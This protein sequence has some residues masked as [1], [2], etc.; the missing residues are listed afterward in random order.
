MAFTAPKFSSLPS[1]ERF[2][3]ERDRIVA[4]SSSLP[5]DV[6]IIPSTASRPLDEACN[7]ENSSSEESGEKVKTKLICMWNN[8]KYRLVTS[9]KVKCK[10]VIYFF[11]FITAGTS[12]PRPI[13]L[14]IHPFGYLEESTI[15]RWSQRLP[16]P[17]YPLMILKHWKTTSP[18]EYGLHIAK[19]FQY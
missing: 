9:I 3:N 5:T 7:R 17:V 14:K 8:V 19:S 18:Q 1:V 4:E 15:S 10:I 16:Q 11:L 6:T 2:P 13:L 12:R